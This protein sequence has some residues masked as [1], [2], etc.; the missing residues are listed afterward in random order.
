MAGLNN[1]AMG[2]AATALKGV[3]LY[4]Q[5]HSGLAGAAGTSNVTTAAR[6]PV[7]WG[8]TS[9]AGDFG[10]AAQ[11]DFTGGASNG[12]IQSVTLWSAITSGTFYGEFI[13]AATTPGVT[14]AFN[15]SG[16]FSLTSLDLDGSAS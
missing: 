1:A 10:L 4:A 5:L 12:P 14:P 8:T 3:L 7:S 2:V 13:V 16:D 15:S 6:K 9:G 11:I